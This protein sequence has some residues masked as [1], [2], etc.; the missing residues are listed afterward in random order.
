MRTIGLLA[1]TPLR[2]F[3]VNTEIDFDDRMNMSGIGNILRELRINPE[4]Q[5]LRYEV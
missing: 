1:V 3:G 2:H 5:S 4:L